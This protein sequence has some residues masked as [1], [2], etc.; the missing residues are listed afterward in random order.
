MVPVVLSNVDWERN[1]VQNDVTPGDVSRNTVAAS[2]ALEACT[3]QF[4]FHN[5]VLEQH[6]LNG[7]DCTTLAKRTDRET[8]AALTVVLKS[9]KSGSDES[10]SKDI[11][12]KLTLRKCTPLAPEPTVMQSSPFCI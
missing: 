9:A 5:Y 6:V 11:N 10:G 7:S 2:P 1:V 12:V 8:M 3:V 4:I